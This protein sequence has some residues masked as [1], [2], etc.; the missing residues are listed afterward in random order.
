MVSLSALWLPILLSAVAVFIVS[1][2]IHMFSPWHK[3]DFGRVPDEARFRP[4]FAALAIPPGEYMVP[5]A[6]SSKEMRTPEFMERVKQGPNVIMTVL[7]NGPWNM[8]RQLGS[9]F[10]YLVIVSLFAGYVAGRALG[11][12]AESP[13]VIRFA[14]TTAFLAYAVALWQTSIWYGRAWSTTIKSTV[15]GLI[16]ALLT[17]AIFCWCWPR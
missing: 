1:S 14:G 4:A 12:G 6:A 9:W 7:P 11:P 15:D 5:R 10:V 8:G 13:E 3:N 2:L 16:Y 17:G